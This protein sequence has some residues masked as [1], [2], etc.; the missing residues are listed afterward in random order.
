MSPS[1]ARF[2]GYEESVFSS[3]TKM[4]KLILKGNFATPSEL[5]KDL[6]RSQKGQCGSFNYLTIGSEQSEGRK[7]GHRLRKKIHP[8]RDPWKCPVVQNQNESYENR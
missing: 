4:C 5:A 3:S 2:Q 7:V 6:I 1:P 8:G